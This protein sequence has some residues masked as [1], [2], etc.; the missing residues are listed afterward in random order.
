M[1]SVGWYSLFVAVIAL[2]RVAETIVSSHNVR[3]AFARGG[4][5]AG[6]SHYPAMVAL[7]A[8]L[9]ASSLAEVWLLRRPW[10]PWLGVAMIGVVA[11]AMAL[12]YWVIWVL[13]GRWTTRV[14]YVPGD[15]LV[16]AGPFRWVRHPNYAAVVAEVAAIPLVHGAWLTAVVFTLANAALL[17]RR[18]RVEEELL[19]RV[20]VRPEEGKHE[21]G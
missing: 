6:A 2:E 10:I 15:P 4:V 7:H 16:A 1:T 19:R 18:I 11:A 12:R 21:R 20:A 13:D 8:A 14:V 3:R 9:L 17:R 5:E